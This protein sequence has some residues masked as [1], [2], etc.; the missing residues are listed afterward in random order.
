MSAAE[1]KSKK[2]NPY[3]V[4][5]PYT[6]ICDFEIGD[7]GE[8]LWVILDNSYTDKSNP[9]A[10]PR[11]VSIKRLWTRTFYRDAEKIRTERNKEEWFLGPEIN[12]GLGLVPFIFCNSRDVEGDKICDSP[13]EDT[14]LKSRKIFNIASW[15]DETLANSS[16]QILFFPYKNDADIKN[17][18]KMFKPDG[19]GMSDIPVIPFNGEINKEPYFGGAK[20]DNIDK[21]IALADHYTDE[22]LAKYGMKTDSKGSWESGVAKSIDFDKT[23]SYLR[24][25][26]RQLEETEKKIA[27]ICGAWENKTVELECKYPDNFEADDIDN[28]L[29]R[30]A[31]A[32]TIPSKKLQQ[33]AHKAMITKIFPDIEQS[34]LDEIIKEIDSDENSVPDDNTGDEDKNSDETLKNKDQSTDLKKDDSK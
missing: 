24:G 33:K 21:Y 7:D 15:C 22:I 9:L 20:L 13:F 32:L 3:A 30:L 28:E 8:P 12:H 31:Q 29:N 5:Y 1:R 10:E 25:V 34:E 17:L 19:S 2:I 27:K 18:T 16:F 26:A 6:N 11:T 23:E 4:Y 14:A